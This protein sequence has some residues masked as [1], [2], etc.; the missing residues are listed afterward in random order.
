MHEIRPR[1]WLGAIEATQDWQRLQDTGITHVITC[2][3]GLET[4]LPAGVDRICSLSIDD[5]DEVDIMEHLPVTSD[6]I[7]KT[8][9][10]SL[11]NR[12]LVH[13]A[14]GKSRSASVVIAYMMREDSMEYCDA[15]SLVQ[16]IRSSA[17]PNSGFT[18]QLAWYGKNGCPMNLCDKITGQKYSDLVDFRKLLRKYT[19]HDVLA[20]VK[21]AG[22]GD[23]ECRDADALQRALNSLDRLQNAMPT[24]DR[25]REAKK[26]ESRRI[27]GALDKL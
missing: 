7:V 23:P 27:N 5:L 9:A 24:D 19:Q 8:L 26:A 22:A 2:G 3:R 17:Q 6:I 11:S 1:L 21:E 14:G 20:L 15:F 12:I 18:H 13:C 16:S 10:A 25:A 4:T